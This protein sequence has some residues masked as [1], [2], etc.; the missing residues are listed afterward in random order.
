MLVCSNINSSLTYS[1][2]TSLLEGTIVKVSIRKKLVL[3]IIVKIKKRNNTKFKIKE[4]E[5]VVFEKRISK[6]I[7][8]FHKWFSFYN[9]VS[10]GLSLKLFLPNERI[11]MDALESSLSI[12]NK[13]DKVKF[14]ETQKKILDFIQNKSS[15]KKKVIEKFKKNSS[16]IKLLIKKNI[17]LENKKK[18]KPEKL[19]N[20]DN[21]RLKRLSDAQ[22]KAYNQIEK[23]ILLDQNKPIFLDGV[24]GA[25]KTEIYFKLIKDSIK[26]KKKVLVLIPEIALSQQWL[27]RFK[28]NFN[29][30]PL[31]W[32]S[33]V[34]IKEKRK[35]WNSALSEEP[36]VLVGARSSLFLPYTNL[37]LIVIDEENDQSYKQ[38]EGIIYNARDM[39]VVKSKIEKCGLILVSAT[40]SLE[41]YNNCK[42]NKYDLVKLEERFKGSK[43]PKTK[44]IDMKKSKSKIISEKTESQIKININ[45]KKQSLILI[46]RRGYAPVSLC[47]SCGYKRKCNNCDTNLV[48]HKE[49]NILMCHYC[50]KIESMEKKCTNCGSK[51]FVLVGC[52][53]E[54][55]YEEVKKLFKTARIIKLS[56]DTLDKESFIKTLKDI[57]ESKIEIIIGTQII[58]KGFDFKNLQSVFIIDFDMWFNN[59]DIRTNEKVFQLTQQVAGRAGRR[60]ERGEL[61]IQTYQPRNQLLFDITRNKRDLFY[62]KELKLRKKNNLPPFSKLTSITISSNS[63]NLAE[64]KAKNLKYL[65]EATKELKVLGPIPAQ[66]FILNSKYRFKLLIKTRN[67]FTIQRYLVKNNI[68]LNTDSKVKVKLD[69]DPHTLY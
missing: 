27:E 17:I 5:A 8:D 7:I 59:A 9:H 2:T 38:E 34:G 21:F 46:N 69:I 10:L 18:I 13:T 61:F 1:H 54:K 57:D 48:Y 45:K 44:I 64:K 49:K 47:I 55:V 67:P 29:F 51:D 28:E 30:Y 42:L 3:G 22:D 53:L 14:T 15:S 36:L 58:S 52:G 11:V 12:E 68:Y 6:R 50:G 24:T 41:T 19:I 25:G 39:A 56:S 60:T 35:I 33:Q 40:P 23:K 20:F 62:E 4:I 16:V 63:S 26:K 65:L 43:H 32:N 66:V 37:G 31:V